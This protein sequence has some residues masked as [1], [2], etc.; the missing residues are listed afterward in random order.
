MLW[1]WVWPKLV[2]VAFGSQRT[3]CGSW[4]SFHQGSGPTEP[5]WQVWWQVPFLLNYSTGLCLCLIMYLILIA[6][7]W[8]YTWLWL[9]C[10]LPATSRVKSDLLFYTYSVKPVTKQLDSSAAR[11]GLHDLY[12]FCNLFLL[13]S[14][15]FFLHWPDWIWLQY[16]TWAFLQ[17]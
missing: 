4:L 6:W 1:V 15:L 7:R 17:R 8:F 13:W 5:R 12:Y 11:L 9:T 16:I 14:F 10:V 3:A 2:M